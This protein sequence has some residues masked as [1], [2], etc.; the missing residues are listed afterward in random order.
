MRGDRVT[1]VT[2][3]PPI[4]GR[5]SCPIATRGTRC[6]AAWFGGIPNDNTG[7]VV[8]IATHNGGMIAE[9]GGGWADSI[10]L[11]ERFWDVC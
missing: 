9:G 8:V 4:T 5:S 7:A 2:V 3:A 10:R 1:T 11:T 6:G